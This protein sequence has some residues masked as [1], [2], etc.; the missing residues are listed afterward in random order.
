MAGVCGPHLPLVRLLY[1]VVKLGQGFFR[2]IPDRRKHGL[3][4]AE[5]GIQLGETR[6]QGRA[7]E[8]R[9]LPLEWEVHLDN[10]VGALDGYRDLARWPQKG[11]TFI[12]WRDAFV[13]D[14]QRHPPFLVV[15]P[16]HRR[17]PQHGRNDDFSA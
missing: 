2:F 10:P 4:A 12:G 9:R 5:I 1:T 7:C 13:Q 17:I 6:R 16:R 14:W 15:K 11:W 3:S 8:P